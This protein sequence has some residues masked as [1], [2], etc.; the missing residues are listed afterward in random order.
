MNK[1]I[2]LYKQI[3][4]IQAIQYSIS[5]FIPVCPIYLTDINENEVYCEFD[6]SN[7][8]YTEIRDEFCNYLIAVSNRS[9]HYA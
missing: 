4:P 6:C 5:S 2:A 1:R 3:Y 7:D 9:D 8:E